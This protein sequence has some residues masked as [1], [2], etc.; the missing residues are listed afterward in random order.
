[1]IENYNIYTYKGRK[2]GKLR[3]ENMHIIEYKLLRQCWIPM[4][5]NVPLSFEICSIVNAQSGLDSPWYQK[6][7]FPQMHSIVSL[8]EI[9]FSFN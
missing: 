5:R 2:R 8:D 9:S 6:K 1:M 3:S 4:R 7:F